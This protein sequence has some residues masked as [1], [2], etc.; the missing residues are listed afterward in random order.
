MERVGIVALAFHGEQRNNHIDA[1]IG[2]PMT[3]KF[4]LATALIAGALASST[5][6]GAASCDT[7]KTKFMWR[8]CMS[9]EI[10][11]LNAAINAKALD[12]CYSKTNSEKGPAAVDERLACRI[13]KLTQA[14]QGMK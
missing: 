13:D 10:D 14:L 6:A 1:T 9:K 11:K 8:S 4:I 7:N 12:L 5:D 3:V 2:I